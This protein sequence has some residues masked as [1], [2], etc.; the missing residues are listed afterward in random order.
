LIAAVVPTKDR[1]DHLERCV[2]SL[3]AGPR[4]PAEII[5]VDQS[6]GDATRRRLERFDGA[7]IRWVPETRASASLARNRGVELATTDYVGLLEDDGEVEPDWLEAALRGIDELGEP[8]ALFGAIAAPAAVDPRSL[9]VSTFSVVAPTVWPQGTHPARVG[10]GGHVVVRREAFLA[11][12]GFDPRLGPGSRFRGAEDMDFNY[13]LLRAGRRVASTPTMRM[14]HHQWREPGALPRLMYGYNLG[15]A[16]MCAKHLRAGD[17]GVLPILRGQAVDDARMLAS[18]VRRRSWL[19][20]RV[21]AY[22]TAGTV[23][24]LVTGWRYFGTTAA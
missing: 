20:A 6:A 14:V 18:A 8:D 5:V 7:A 22:R 12:G 21:A 13:R 17:R 11:E 3:L 9:E 1:P 10:Y 23:G 19:R 24:G 4:P 15:Q 16:A 2:R